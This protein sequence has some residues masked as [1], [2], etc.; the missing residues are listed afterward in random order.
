MDQSLA[1][2]FPDFIVVIFV[3]R[4]FPF[5]LLLYFAILYLQRAT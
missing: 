1:S 3:K 4:L 2:L 5:S